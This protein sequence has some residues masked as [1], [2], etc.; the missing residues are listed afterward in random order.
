MGD[1][2]QAKRLLLAEYEREQQELSIV[3]ARLR[4]ELVRA[5]DESSRRAGTRRWAGNQQKPEG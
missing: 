4:R 3:I 5:S 1:I 2:N